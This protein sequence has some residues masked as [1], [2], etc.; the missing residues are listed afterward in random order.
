MTRIDRI[1]LA[2]SSKLSDQL[3]LDL[4]VD[5]DLATLLRETEGVDPA[6]SPV[7]AERI[8][9]REHITEPVVGLLLDKNLDLGDL[10]DH[11]SCVANLQTSLLYKDAELVEF[12]GDITKQRVAAA[13]DLSERWDA[14]E[15]ICDDFA[16]DLDERH[17]F[18]PEESQLVSEQLDATALTLESAAGIA[19]RRAA[20]DEELR[21]HLETIAN[22]ARSSL[23]KEIELIA[24][25]ER[26]DH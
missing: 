12:A 3:D 20:A 26:Y 8:A 15:T 11:L 18:N 19:E 14:E 10:A 9:V 5:D 23:I 13:T 24:A 22:L 7:I 25:A 2:A 17:S 16:A 21:L 1:E 6:E 4:G